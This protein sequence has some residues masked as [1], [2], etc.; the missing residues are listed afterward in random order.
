M[1]TAENFLKFVILPE[2]PNECWGWSGGKSPNGRGRFR[3]RNAYVVSYELFVGPIPDKLTIDHLCRNPECSNPKHLEAVTQQVNTLRGVGPSAL[4]AKK[5]HCPQGHEYTPENTYYR[6]KNHSRRCR[7]CNREKGRRGRT[8]LTHCKNGHERTT[9]NTMI[10]KRGW[11]TCIVCHRTHTRDSKRRQ[12][13]LKE[14]TR[15]D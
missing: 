8:Y 2:D 7:T 12:E 4:N 6:G 9:E 13:A 14:R 3:N 1:I 15:N 10:T 11:K 5:T